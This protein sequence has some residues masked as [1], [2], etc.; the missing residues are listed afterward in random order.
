MGGAAHGLGGLCSRSAPLGSVRLRS[1]P[2]GSARLRPAPVRACSA[3]PGGRAGA[4]PAHALSGPAALRAALCASR[5]HFLL[6]R[7]VSGSLPSPLSEAVG[8]GL[9]KFWGFCRFWCRL[10][11]FFFF[12]LFSRGELPP[13]GGGIGRAARARRRRRPGSAVGRGAD[14][15]GRL[16]E[17]RGRGGAGGGRGPR[18]CALGLPGRSAASQF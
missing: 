2:P 9:C 13:R 6:L 17:A 12:N 5:F 4:S 7:A 16:A 10:I 11:K 8:L 14:G 18:G 15:R 3:P 1:A